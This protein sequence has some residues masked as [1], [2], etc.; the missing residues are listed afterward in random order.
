MVF[1]RS[2]DTIGSALTA[3]RYRTD[4]ILQNISNA[5][6]T[7]TPGGGPYTRQQVVFEERPL[8]GSFFRQSYMRA[9]TRYQLA[10]Q[11]ALPRQSGGVR[12]QQMVDSINEF[13]PVYDPNHPDADANGYVLYPNVDTT[14]EMIDLMAASN[15]YEA[16]LAAYS[17]VRGMI[18]RALD[19][20]R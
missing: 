10:R 15:S 11:A 12:I 20:G 7:R 19:M 9:Q 1:L 17:V 2:L 4:V 6:T 16:Q 3:E 5:R 14:E 18:N 13:K 8:S